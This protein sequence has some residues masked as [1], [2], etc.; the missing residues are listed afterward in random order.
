MIPHQRVYNSS[1]AH[2]NLCCTAIQLHSHL[3]LSACTEKY[4]MTEFTFHRTRFDRL[5]RR[6]RPHLHHRMYH[7]SPLHHSHKADDV[8]VPDQLVCFDLS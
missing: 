7:H 5:H 6:S 8:T 4:V 2:L 3:F 1:S